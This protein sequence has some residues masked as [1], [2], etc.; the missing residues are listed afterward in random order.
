MNCIIVDDELPSR[1]ELVYF[2]ENH[3]HIE[4]AAQ[5][6]NALSALEYLKSHEPDVI[7][8]DI[9][10]PKLD[11]ISMGKILK[12]FD[13][14]PAVVY[15][16]AYREHAADAFEIEAF[17]YILKPFPQDRILHT[18]KKLENLEAGKSEKVDENG[19]GSVQITKT[20]GR[21]ISDKITLWKNDKMFVVNVEDISY[22]EVHEREVCVLSKNEKYLVNSTITEFQKKLPP[23]KFFR[24][25]RSYI[26]NLDQISE[27]IPWFN[28]TYM[29]KIKGVL[30]NIPVSRNKIS[31]FKRAMG[32]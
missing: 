31:E 24:C 28:N 7:F 26:V 17:D 2:I 22:C 15:V 11:G 18:L 32:I 16:T 10:M 25:H 19:Q 1:Q 20:E 8:L 6:D 3:S 23:D 4:I 27:I 13:M 21:V 30:E 9:N 5:F 12:T 29:L 14:K